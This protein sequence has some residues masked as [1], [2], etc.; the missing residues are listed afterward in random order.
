MSSMSN[1]ISA[2]T[3]Y[4]AGMSIANKKPQETQSVPS[5]SDK[6]S[7]TTANVTDILDISQEAQNIDQQLQLVTDAYV[8]EKWQFDYKAL[9]S[10]AASWDDYNAKQAEDYKESQIA[11]GKTAFVN[12]YLKNTL[13]DSAWRVDEYGFAIQPQNSEGWRFSNGVAV[14]NPSEKFPAEFMDD[15]AFQ[16]LIQNL[17]KY[18]PNGEDYFYVSSSEFAVGYSTDSNGRITGGV[19]RLSGSIS[20]Q[21]MYQERNPI[22][23][24][25]LHENAQPN[26]TFHFTTKDAASLGGLG[27]SERKTFFDTV[28]SILNK[29]GVRDDQGKILDAR[30]MRYDCRPI[31]LGG[32]DD[33]FV[34]LDFF[35]LHA[36]GVSSD[37][38]FKINEIL[39]ANSTLK[40]LGKK[41]YQTRNAQGEGAY[42]IFMTDTSGN[43]LA[44]D[45]I[46]LEANGKSAI[47]SNEDYSKMGRANVISYVAQNGK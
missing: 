10:C 17:D 42:K 14:Y 41:A 36:L 15:I 16:K 43:L 7:H 34:G 23:E 30:Q 35:S 37:D 33:Y 18:N 38:W 26:G 19:F 46:R 44:K 3:S 39:T 29:S 31:P 1:S 45:Q 21:P 24:P 32:P 27:L 13:G 12:D 25:I 4:E 5:S 22:N 11:A 47:I 6:I 40:S 8:W 20:L 2:F 28:Q 9:L